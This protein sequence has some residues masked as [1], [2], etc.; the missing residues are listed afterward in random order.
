MLKIRRSRDCLIFKIGIPY[1]ER[2]YLYWDGA[3]VAKSLLPW[4][5]HGSGHSL[6]SLIILKLDKSDLRMQARR[7]HPHPLRAFPVYI[8]FFCMSRVSL[9]F[10]SGLNRQTH[11]NIYPFSKFCGLMPEMTFFLISYLLRTP[12][13]NDRHLQKAFYN[14]FL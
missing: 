13:L 14:A 3:Q 4:V 7:H 5:L 8:V 9:T 2:R 11:A 10:K 12:F 1:L 6:F